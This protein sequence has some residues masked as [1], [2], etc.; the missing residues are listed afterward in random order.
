VQTDTIHTLADLEALYGPANPTSLLKE[1]AHLTPAYRQWLEAAP[2]FA[3]ATS[4]PKGLDCS[5]RGDT[6]GALLILDDRTLAIPDRRGNNRLDSLRN[7]IGDPRVGLL[8]MIP[9][10]NETL[11]INGRAVLSTSPELIGQFVVNGQSP[12]SVI[13]V[14]IEAVYFQCARALAR[15]KLWD[16]G[17]HVD[18]QHV[19]KPG[20]MV[21]SVLP[22]FDGKTYDAS[23]AERQAATLY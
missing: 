19:P 16:T 11:R 17:A 12:K 23:L 15:S 18:A 5:P 10:I 13:V 9:G 7:I 22:D 21:Q 1:T 8:F 20:Q 4:G 2:F 6:T 3:L 14:A